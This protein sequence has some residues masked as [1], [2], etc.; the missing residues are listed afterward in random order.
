MFDSVFDQISCQ[1]RTGIGVLERVD[2]LPRQGEINSSRGLSESFGFAGGC[3]GLP[4]SVSYVY[5]C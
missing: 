1:N 3:D 2:F 5:V 4:G